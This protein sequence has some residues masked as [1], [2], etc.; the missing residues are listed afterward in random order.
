MTQRQSERIKHH[1]GPLIKPS[2]VSYT[3]I[4]NSL[5]RAVI[6]E[7]DANFVNHHGFDW[8]GIEVA[9][10]KDLKRKTW[11]AGGSTITQQLA[12]NLFLSTKRN[13]FRKAEEVIITIMLENLW[14]KKRIL[15]VYLNVIEWGD[16]I[17]GCAFAAQHYFDVPVQSINVY[18]AAKLASMIPRPRF[19][20]KNGNTEKLI[21][22]TDTIQLRMEQV[23]IP[24]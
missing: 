15:E 23:E 11:I 3:S 12:K 22:K 4:P 24:K 8:L 21:E 19:Y 9:F 7:E 1:K 20:D 14:S 13:V 17:F 10:K 16:G 18:Q 6:A 2:W 5:K